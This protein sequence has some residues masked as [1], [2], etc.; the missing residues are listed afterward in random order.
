MSSPPVLALP[1]FCKTFTMECDASGHGLGVVLMQEK[2]PIAFHSQALKGRALALS[3]Y[4]KEFFALITIVKKW[5]PYLVVIGHKLN[6]P[7]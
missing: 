7:L 6:D 1:D 3:T 4:E 2:R 5:R